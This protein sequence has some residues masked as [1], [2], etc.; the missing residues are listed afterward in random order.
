MTGKM[1]VV[2]Y[3]VGSLLR[4]VLGIQSAHWGGP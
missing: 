2:V 4:L 3:M 1:R